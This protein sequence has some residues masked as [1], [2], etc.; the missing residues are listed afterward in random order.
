[1]KLILKTDDA[2]EA[3]RLVKANDM[4]SFIWEL[5]NNGWRDFKH[6]DYDYHPAWDKISTLLEE[7]NINIEDLTE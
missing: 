2:M 3:K 7:Y 4:A 1:M 5:V 6:T